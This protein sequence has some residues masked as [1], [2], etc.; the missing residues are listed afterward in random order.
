M[1]APVEE[2]LQQPGEGGE[3][4]ATEV[5]PAEPIVLKCGLLGD[6]AVG[7]S[8]MMTY[9][10]EGRFTEDDIAT[11]G[12]S[13]LEKTVRLR[14]NP[15]TYSIFDVGGSAEFSHMLPLVCNDA[16]ALIFMFDLSRR[17]SLLNIKEWYGQARQYNKSAHCFLVGSKFD[18]FALLPPEEQADIDKL[19][20]KY[21]KAMKSP[22]V[23]TS[24]S[25]AINVQK[26]FKLILAKAFDIKCNIQPIDQ[27]GEPI[28]LI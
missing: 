19:A 15:I 22:L 4:E 18:L 16:V 10:V 8:S 28:L 13:T 9:F 23:F 20:R 11:L 21:A 6:P 5:L 26:L 25:H 7:K 1:T 14:G 12:V 17:S 3:E 24:S 2:P 27:V